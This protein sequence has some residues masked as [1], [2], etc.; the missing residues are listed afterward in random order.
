MYR[1]SYRSRTNLSTCVTPMQRLFEAVLKKVDHTIICGH[2]GPLEQNAAYDAGKSTVRYPNSK[3][4]PYPSRAVDVAP[5]PINWNDLPR[6]YKFAEVVYETAKE[7]GIEVRW[8]GDWDS[9]GDFSDQT[10][11]D[12]VHWELIKK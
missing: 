8:G 2:R 3:H 6:F 9:D 4:N 5:Y 11:N 12:L 10:F 1:Y 7:M